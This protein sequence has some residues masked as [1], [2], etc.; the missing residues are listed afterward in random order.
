MKVLFIVKTVDFIDPLGLAELSA[1]AK[2]NGHE[3]FLGITSREDIFSKIKR[4]RPDVIAYSAITGEHKYYFKLN[5]VIKNRYKDI[6]TIM[7]GPHTT[8]YP[9]CIKDSAFDAICVGE[10]DEA[11]H[12]R[13]AM[14]CSILFSGRT[15]ESHRRGHIYLQPDTT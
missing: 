15:K 7:G 12:K 10:G 13:K 2:F 6:F 4:I 14:P 5:E 11:V 1:R 3:T 8:F 9:G